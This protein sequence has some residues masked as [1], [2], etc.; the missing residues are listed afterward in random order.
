MSKS[1]FVRKYPFN[2]PAAEVVAAAKKAG[3]KITPGLV[4]VVRTTDRRKARKAGQPVPPGGRRGRRTKVDKNYL[5]KPGVEIPAPQEIMPEVAVKR[6]E[7]ATHVHDQALEVNGFVVR[8]PEERDLCELTLQVGFTRAA[9]L[10]NGFRE[11]CLGG[12][13]S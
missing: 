2:V 8:S 9:E 12:L 10:L 11:R 7:R 1:E 6:R 13:K 4:H 5:A 3:L